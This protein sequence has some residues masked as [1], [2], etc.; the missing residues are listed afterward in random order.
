M[1]AREMLEIKLKQILLGYAARNP[2]YE[3]MASGTVTR[4]HLSSSSA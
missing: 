4:R 3:F 2:T 1:V